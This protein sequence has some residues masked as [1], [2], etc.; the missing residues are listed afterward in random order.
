MQVGL[1]ALMPSV[2]LP[3]HLEAGGLQ[4]RGLK[5]PDYPASNKF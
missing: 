2:D 5:I 1:D 3:G 4:K